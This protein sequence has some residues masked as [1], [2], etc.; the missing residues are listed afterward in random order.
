MR[1]FLKYFLTVYVLGVALVIGVAGF[2]G[3][4]T[5]RT[6]IEVFPD[7]DRQ[8]KLRPQT[9]TKF[10]QWTD[11][12]TSRPHP[13][14][15]VS[16]EASWEDNAFN[17]GKEG[18]GFVEVMPIAVN[19]TVLKR[20]QEKFTVYCQPCHGVLG[21][22]K[23]I[24]SKFGMGNVANLHQDRLVKTQDGDIFNTISYGKATMIGYAGAIPV[25][26]R[27]AIV[28]Y[29]RTLQLSRLVNGSEVPSALL[30]TIK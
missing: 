23:G 21:D 1:T 14:G 9:T 20:G 26:D 19:A 8:P 5:T 15:T 17:T 16:R 4:K 6:P 29:V 18:A 11:A 28:S 3:S 27:W 12:Q 2:R 10:A 24:T 7:M 13:S 22:G 30:P 25:S